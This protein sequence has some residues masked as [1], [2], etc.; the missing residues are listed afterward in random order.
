MSGSR[1]QTQLILAGLA[2]AAAG[3]LLIYMI[4][5]A[6][7]KA[8]AD[9]KNDD[10]DA[11]A[12]DKTT[13]N[14]ATTTSTTRSM[15]FNASSATPKA[16]GRSNSISAD[17][18]DTE[19][20][21]NKSAAVKK[22][23]ASAAS[24]PSSSTGK[25]DDK[26]LHAK[27]EEMDK[28]GKVLFKE[29]K[30]LE[31][32]QAF[33]DAIDF[34][35]NYSNNKK[36]ASSSLN[37]QII[38]LI[39]NRSAMYEKGSLPEL[40]LEDCKK[41]L[42]DYDA[43]H[44][45]ARTRKLRILEQFQQHYNALVEVCTMQLLYMQQ[46]R[47]KLR[48]GLPPSSPPPVPQS[49]L[50]ELVSLCVPEA[51]K[52]WT[53][54]LE[55]KNAETT[56]LPAD[57]TLAQLL[58]SYTGYNAWMSKA[59]KDGSVASIDQQLNIS[60]NE[61]EKAS[62]LMKKG[63][64]Y[65][66]DGDYENARQTILQGYQLIHKKP[67]ISDLMKDD[68]H[69]RLLEWTGMIKHWAFDLDGANACYE[70]CAALESLNAEILVKQAGVAMDATK[71]DKAL[72][73]FEKALQ[74][75]PN[76]VDAL[77][78]RA[79]LRMLQR[80]LPEAE[81]DLRRCI[82]LRPDHI[83][84]H[85]RLAAVLSTTNDQAGAKRCLEKAEKIN[86]NSS[87]VQSYRGEFLFTEND[88]EGAK[89]YFE[90][91]MEMEPK[92][93]TPYVNAAVA[94]LNSPPQQAGEQMQMAQKAVGFLEKAIAV[95]AQFNAAYIQLGQLKLGM[96]TDLNA[97]EEVIDLYE[98]GLQNCRTQEEMREL[99]SMSMLARA[100]VDAARQLKMETFNMA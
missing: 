64:R 1:R 62:L 48:M 72:K 17:S 57:Y 68:D 3:S 86:P 92:N 70:A 23:K 74:I 52:E 2:A 15:G 94:I 93:P 49:K 88:F 36:V 44:T 45:K 19:T 81:K 51:L 69:A 10:A 25:M 5:S 39:N 54:K 89:S 9:D 85:L 40:A 43:T 27:I 76:A 4:A 98:K 41:I 79:N 26:A 16:K 22:Q 56:S 90:K 59:A 31:A 91:A 66:F 53:D 63:R 87:E 11:S 7:S 100:Q 14:A 50:E 29:K 8:S 38:T 65:V 84:A 61:H 71:H 82:E 6:S 47:D 34:I 35:E 77:L 58:K 83:L 67:E 30:F 80:N 78:H 37:R 46:N 28:Q 60:Q 13:G 20:I 99:C 96:S 18:T 12:S 55:M 73:L 42:D 95:D 33:S 32:A 97:A 24:S 21:S 75:D